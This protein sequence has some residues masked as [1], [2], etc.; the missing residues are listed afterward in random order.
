MIW[1]NSVLPVYIG[2]SGNISSERIA[3]PSICIQVDT[4]QNIVKML[5]C[6]M[7]LSVRLFLNRTALIIPLRFSNPLFQSSHR[8]SLRLPASCTASG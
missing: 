4:T 1:A 8:N 5:I 3:H 7:V 2:T 6:H